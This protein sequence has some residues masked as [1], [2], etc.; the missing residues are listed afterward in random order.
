MPVKLS[1][2]EY[3]KLYFPAKSERTVR[4]IINSQSLPPLHRVTV[5]G[6]KTVI[7]VE[8]CEHIKD[9]ILALKLFRT[10]DRSFASG[11]SIAINNGLN[12]SDFLT[13]CGLK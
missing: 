2:S 8:S 11:V 3:H 5:C 1:I 13:I 12:I 10:T 9:Y 4:R 6:C 7:E